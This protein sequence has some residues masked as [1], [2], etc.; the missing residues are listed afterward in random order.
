MGEMHNDVYGG[1]GWGLCERRTDLPPVSMAARCHQI[2]HMHWRR[3]CLLFS[4]LIV[5]VNGGWGSV[6]VYHVCVRGGNPPVV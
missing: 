6:C 4:R 1:V 3:T 5:C 2:S